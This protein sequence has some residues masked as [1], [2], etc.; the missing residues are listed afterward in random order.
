MTEI[1][2]ENNSPVFPVRLSPMIRPTFY[3][4]TFTERPVEPAC[5]LTSSD[6]CMGRW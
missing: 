5:F 6:P 1:D 3:I 2:L 4:R